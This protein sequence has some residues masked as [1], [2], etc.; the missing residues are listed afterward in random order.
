[1]ASNWTEY[2]GT[3]YNTKATLDDIHV[4][5]DDGKYFVDVS[6][7]IEDDYTKSRLHVHKIALPIKSDMIV[8]HCA[9]CCGNE[10]L[11]VSF[12]EE[13]KLKAVPDASGN[14][15]TKTV[16]EERPHEMTLAEIEEEL[17]YKIK[18]VEK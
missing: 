2:Y 10:H 12:G 14:L 17:G 18:I 1:M 3:K 13:C 8:L 16:I 5:E 6:Y 15:Y 7:I 4:Y 11:S 9:T